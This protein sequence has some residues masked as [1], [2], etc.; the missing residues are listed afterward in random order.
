MLVYDADSQCFKGESSFSLLNEG[1]E[2]DGV[3]EWQLHFK[4]SEIKE[5]SYGFAPEWCLGIKVI[6]VLEIS[7]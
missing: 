1:V 5:V 6:T 7:G 2:H 3:E 4:I